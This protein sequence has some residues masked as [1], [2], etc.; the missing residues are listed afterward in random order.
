MRAPHVS[1]LLLRQV[2]AS[3]FDAGVTIHALGGTQSEA[4]H[5]TQSAIGNRQSAIGKS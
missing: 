2:G 5:V 1:G 4:Y 3:G